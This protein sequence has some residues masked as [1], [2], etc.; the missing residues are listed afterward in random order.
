MR[1]ASALL[2]QITSAAT[3]EASI[4]AAA[5]DD[6]GGRGLATLAYESVCS[7]PDCKAS[8][9]AGKPTALV[10]HGLLGSGYALPHLL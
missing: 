10:V 5:S 2:Q 7:K 9:G 4:L 1:R 8:A 3:H 6:Q